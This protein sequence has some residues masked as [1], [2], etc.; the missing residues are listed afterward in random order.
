MDFTII[1]NAE[2]LKKISLKYAI[3]QY[4]I[5]QRTLTKIFTLLSMTGP[6]IIDWS[7][8]CQIYRMIQIDL[9]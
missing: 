6:D 3:V 9:C 8:F 4:T 7:K 5:F 2:T 1:V